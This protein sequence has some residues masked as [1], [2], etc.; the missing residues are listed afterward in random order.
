VATGTGATMKRW[1]SDG[2]AQFTYWQKLLQKS[3]VAS[4]Q[5]VGET[6][7]REAQFPQ[8]NSQTSAG[9]FSSC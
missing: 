3:K 4:V 1:A 5:I 9:I 7:K 6:L 8:S 2:L